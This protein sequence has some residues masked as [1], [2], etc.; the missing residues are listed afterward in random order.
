MRCS[1]FRAV[2]LGIFVSSACEA[3]AQ[4]DSPQSR[5][6]T[7]RF[8]QIAPRPKVENGGTEVSLAERIAPLL[9]TA[10]ENKWLQIP[11]RTDVLAARRE[12]ARQGKPIF[13]WL[14]DGDPLGCT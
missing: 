14:M 11:W 4:D 12:A 7:K 13:M 9:P 5:H 2:L 3:V 8:E 6:L 1:T 10:K